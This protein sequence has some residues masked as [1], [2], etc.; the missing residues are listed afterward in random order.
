[1]EAADRN[2]RA[3]PSG[4][5]GKVTAALGIDVGGTKI[6]AGVVD[7]STGAVLERRQV[8]TR[9]ERGGAAVLG[10]CAEL[11]A[12][13]GGGRL[14]VGIGLCE[15]VDLDGRPS[16]ADTIDWRDLDP[17]AAIEAPRV[18]VESDL[19]A[20]ALAE[21]RFGAGAGVS[22]FLFAVVGTGASACLVVDG[23]PYA[24]GRGEAL[25]L[26]APPV[27][28]VASGPAL[29]RAAGLER[30]EDVLADPA[31]A[32]LVDAAAAALGSVL[33]VLANALDPS[34]DRAR[35]RSRRRAGVPGARRAGV[36]GAARVP[37]HSAASGRRL[38]P[39]AGRRRD[40]SGS[41]GAFGPRLGFASCS[42]ET[43]LWRDVTELPSS[44]AATLEDRAGIEEVAAL[45]G[46]DGVRRVVASGN[47]AAY[48]VAV[49]LWLASLEGS[50]GPE[51]VA[52][53][54]GLLA[55]GAFAWRP[56]DVLL[57]VSSSGE[58]RDLVEAVDAGAP[59]PFAAVTATAGST[60]GSRAGARALVSVPNQRAVTHT[61]AFCGAVVAAL[62][63]WAAVTS[64]PDLDAV[65]PPSAGASS[66]APSPTPGRGSTS[67]ERSTP[68]RRS[69]SGAARRGP[70]R[71]RLHCC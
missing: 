50:A 29:A 54:S 14:P 42:T 9:P 35:R 1:M 37:P 33:A 4:V 41:R 51:V 38:A 27:E 23:R 65:A 31:H 39:R 71:S 21:A 67:S 66:S 2:R 58:F 8:P 45:V 18:V 32:P 19:R 48:Y 43:G 60:L 5:D 53:P 28:R 24:G 10:D 46:A 34:L 26:G 52:V 36:P 17:A 3:A 69:S 12:E 44:L 11:A 70:R 68:R 63:V 56:G 47:G 62:G 13:L 61:Q 57:A 15:L 25:V 55:R 20:A 6:A 16:S 7:P 49:A 59:T 30:A 64:D 22:P 40:R